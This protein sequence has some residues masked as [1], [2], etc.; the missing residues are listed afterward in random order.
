MKPK[1]IENHVGSASF[2]KMRSLLSKAWRN[3]HAPELI[4]D[5]TVACAIEAEWTARTHVGQPTLTQPSPAFAFLSAPPAGWCA[6]S[7]PTEQ[8]VFK[9]YDTFA[10]HMR[11]L[12]P[13]WRAPGRQAERTYTGRDRTSRPSRSVMRSPAAVM[14]IAPS[15]ERTM[16]G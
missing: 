4:N 15:A 16:S 11:S 14:T 1:E 9:Y 2:E 8:G 13:D 7:A 6:A 5:E 3:A 12:F 10:E